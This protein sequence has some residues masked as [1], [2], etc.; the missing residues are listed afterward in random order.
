MVLV[1][2]GVDSVDLLGCEGYSMRGGADHG[3]FDGHEGGREDFF[4][5]SAEGDEAVV[6]EPDGFGRGS[7]LFGVLFGGVADGAGE[8]E[9][10]VNV[11]HPGAGGAA[12]DDFVGEIASARFLFG[13]Q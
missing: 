4:G 1:G 5:V 11:G 13:V 12:A 2:A 3:C 6:L 7:P 9:A 10:G 8:G